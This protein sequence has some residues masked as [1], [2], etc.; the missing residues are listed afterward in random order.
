MG[1]SPGGPMSQERLRYQSHHRLYFVLEQSR[2]VKRGPAATPGNVFP[3]FSHED[4]THKGKRSVI[5]S[6][7]DGTKAVARGARGTCVRDACKFAPGKTFLASARLT[8][9]RVQVLAS[10]RAPLQSRD[11]YNKFAAP[12]PR[13][14]WLHT[15]IGNKTIYYKT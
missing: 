6:N 3:D 10:A 8:A 4:F 13:R 9:A 12:R 11:P 5:L 14:R 15:N 2:R 1:K 7:Y